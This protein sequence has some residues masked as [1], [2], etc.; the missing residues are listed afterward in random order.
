[1]REFYQDVKEKKSLVSSARHRKCGSKSKFVSLPHDNMTPAQWRKKNGVV[2]TYDLKAPMTWAQFK[3]LPNDLKREYITYLQ[4]E[5]SASGA[6]I[7]KCFGI[8][9]PYLKAHMDK[10]GVS[11]AFPKGRMKSESV[12]R[13]NAFFGEPEE[14]VEEQPVRPVVIPRLAVEG[15]ETGE[16]VEEK[17]AAPEK[18]RMPHFTL[19]FDGPFD[20][21]TVANSL[22]FMI[23]DGTKCSIEIKVT[24]E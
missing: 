12:D 3:E 1:M 6:A 2:S 10:S 8:T 24:K 18:M 15:A 20:L 23:G 4:T 7:A 5:F 17:S 21:K 9:Q 11:V 14:Q 16:P 19:N 22:Q 13:L